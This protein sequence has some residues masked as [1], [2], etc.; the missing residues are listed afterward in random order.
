MGNKNR[1]ISSCR[2]ANARATNTDRHPLF[3]S[4]NSDTIN[5]TNECYKWTIVCCEPN[6]AQCG[7]IYE[8]VIWSTQTRKSSSSRMERN[9]PVRRRSFLLASVALDIHV[10][11]NVNFIVCTFVF[12]Y[13]WLCRKAGDSG[14]LL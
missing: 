8:E 4:I 7:Q 5:K 10:L 12:V 1:N 11:C 3:I 6:S 14:I 13:F 9:F 2:N